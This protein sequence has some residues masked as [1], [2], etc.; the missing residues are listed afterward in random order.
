MASKIERKKINGTAEPNATESKGAF[1][2][3]LQPTSH[4]ESWDGWSK[5]C[6]ATGG[7]RESLQGESHDGERMS[8][9]TTGG[10]KRFSDYSP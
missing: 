4:R 3:E 8:N 1:V 6:R 10:A 7:G 9:G 2:W 5:H